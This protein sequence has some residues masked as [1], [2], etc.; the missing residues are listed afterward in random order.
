MP[1]ALLNHSWNR[2]ETQ[3][4]AG[5]RKTWVLFSS[6]RWISPSALVSNHRENTESPLLEGP[7]TEFLPRRCRAVSPL[8]LDHKFKEVAFAKGCWCMEV[9]QVSTC[10]VKFSQYLSFNRYLMKLFS[11]FTPIWVWLELEWFIQISFFSYRRILLSVFARRKKIIFYF[12][13]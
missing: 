5:C 9:S 1:R 7:S 13:I 10:S 4:A 12:P 11:E 2:C 6:R 8:V 3:A